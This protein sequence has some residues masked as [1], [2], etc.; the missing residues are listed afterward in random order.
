[1]SRMTCA[2]LAF[3][4]I[5]VYVYCPSIIRDGTPFHSAKDPVWR[6]NPHLNRSLV[7]TCLW[8]LAL[9]VPWLMLFV[10]PAHSYVPRRYST[11][12]RLKKP[13]LTHSLQAEMTLLPLIS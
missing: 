6:G 3:Q 4:T 7:M 13:P 9:G 11:S 5:L 1:M 8:T 12:L 10:S 2:F